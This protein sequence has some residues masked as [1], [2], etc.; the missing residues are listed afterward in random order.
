[1]KYEIWKMLSFGSGELQ[2][3]ILNKSFE[4]FVDAYVQFQKLIKT[5]SRCIILNEGENK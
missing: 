4:N 1:M 5:T 2:P 3:L